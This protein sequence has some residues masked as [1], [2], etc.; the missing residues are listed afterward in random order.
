Y[1]NCFAGKLGCIHAKLRKGILGN[2]TIQQ[3]LRRI[4]ARIQQ[5]ASLAERFT[6]SQLRFLKVEPS[7]QARSTESK[8]GAALAVN[9]YRIARRNEDVFGRRRNEMVILDSGGPSAP[10]QRNIGLDTRGTQPAGLRDN[11]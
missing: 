10:L 2:D 3:Y 4:G 1:R 11:I 7:V 5:T 9:E 8:I 6:Q